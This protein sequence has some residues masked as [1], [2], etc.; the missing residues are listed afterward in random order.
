MP[1]W[2]CTE[3]DFK[4][5]HT[6][7]AEE[8]ASRSPPREAGSSHARFQ[9]SISSKAKH[10][11]AQSGPRQPL[12]SGRTLNSKGKGGGHGGRVKQSRWPQDRAGWGHPTYANAN[13]SFPGEGFPP[14]V[15]EGG[16]RKGLDRNKYQGSIVGGGGN[17][18][19]D[20][21]LS[22]LHFFLQ[23]SC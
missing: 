9:K 12:P 14:E 10:L 18:E 23:A 8:K 17:R 20:P 4:V 2:P 6:T 16:H 15:L 22:L 11:T 3:G 7:G 13:P 19:T 5:G 1:L 21:I